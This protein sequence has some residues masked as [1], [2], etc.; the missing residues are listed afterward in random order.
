MTTYSDAIDIITEETERW[1]NARAWFQLE[2]DEDA[3]NAINRELPG[4][5]T[6]PDDED[7]YTATADEIRKAVHD[8]LNTW[9][10]GAI[11]EAIEAALECESDEAADWFRD[12]YP[13]VQ[14]GRLLKSGKFKAYS[15]PDAEWH[16]PLTVITSA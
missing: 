7:Y 15:C 11:N 16:G 3:D 12:V 10:H 1:F 6:V 8:G 9:C 5:T 14:E 2:K 4:L 13:L